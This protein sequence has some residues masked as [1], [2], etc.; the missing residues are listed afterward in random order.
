MTRHPIIAGI[1]YSITASLLLGGCASENDPPLPPQ[2]Q[3]HP[4]SQSQTQSP[5]LSL[6]DLSQGINYDCWTPV[7]GNPIP[8][9]AA[10]VADCRA[11]TIPPLRNHGPHAT[12][13]ISVLLN[14]AAQPTFTDLNSPLPLGSAIVKLKLNRG[15]EITS[16]GAMVKRETGYWPGNG[17]WEYFYAEYDKDGTSL[18]NI[19]HGRIESCAAC[20][21]QAE[22][23]DYVFRDYLE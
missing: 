6:D 18:I 2:S 1:A 17:D 5:P 12:A 11:V 15:H 19:T 22:A 10:I 9:Q 21:Q 4:Q 16:Y 13:E 7:T 23:S 8:V 14:P 3:S 20:H